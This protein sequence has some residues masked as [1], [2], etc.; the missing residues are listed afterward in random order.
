MQ[1][2]SIDNFCVSSAAVRNVPITMILM[3]GII[4]HHVSLVSSK[5]FT[6]QDKCLSLSYPFLQMHLNARLGLWRKVN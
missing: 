1:L 2:R 3:Q 4:C 5:P 6:G